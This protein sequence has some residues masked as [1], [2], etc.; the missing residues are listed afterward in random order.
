MAKRKTFKFTRRS[1]NILKT[2]KVAVSIVKLSFLSEE[3]NKYYIIRSGNSEKYP[4][5]RYIQFTYVYS[6]VVFR[7]YDIRYQN[8][9]GDQR[10]NTN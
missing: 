5:E 8:E 2:S 3:R 7:N 4:N 10:T 6:L 9:K 1:Y